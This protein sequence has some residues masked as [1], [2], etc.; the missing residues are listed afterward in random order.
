MIGRFW[1]G[2]YPLVRAWWMGYLLP[3]V[4]AGAVASSADEAGLAV[5]AVWVPYYV[6]ASVGCWRSA[7]AYDGTRAWRILAKLG[8]VAHTVVGAVVMTLLALFVAGLAAM[9]H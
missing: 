1:R 8:I 6:L 2:D 4:V 7:N 3:G 5:A 9:A